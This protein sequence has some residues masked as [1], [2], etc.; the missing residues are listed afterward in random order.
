MMGFAAI[1]LVTAL[2]VSFLMNPV[3]MSLARKVGAIDMPRDRHIH[4]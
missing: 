2:V 3:V 4:K 1:A